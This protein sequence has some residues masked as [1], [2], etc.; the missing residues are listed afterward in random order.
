MHRLPYWRLSA[1]YFSYFAFIGVFSP[2]FGL[3]LQSLSFSAWDIGVVMSQMQ[4]MRLFAP[5]LAGGL[6]DR[7]QKRILIVRTSSAAA[8]VVFFAFLFSNTF[9]TVLTAMSV[10]SFCW[11]AALPLVETLTFD[12]LRENPARYS[13]IRVWGSIG[14]VVAVLGTG[15][16]L[17][18]VAIA[19]LVWIGLGSLLC[20]F[21]SAAVVPDAE[22]HVSG[23]ERRPVGQILR[24]PRV[25][26]LFAA[27]FAAYAAHAALNIFYSILLSDH[28]Y[29]KS[30][31]GMLWT[32]GVIVE[33]GVFFFMPR[34]MRRFN[35]RVILLASL[36][37]AVVRFVMIGA[38]VDLPAILVFAQLLHG[39]T[40]GSFH[41]AAIAAVNRWFP[42]STRSRGQ[43][44]YS[45]LSF[46]AGG[47]VGGLL[48]GWTWG[49][50]GGEATFALSSVYALIGFLLVARY[51]KKSDVSEQPATGVVHAT[52]NR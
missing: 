26:A 7:L 39:L 50:L 20:I 47:L 8:L 51:V 9:L 1:Y 30:A 23:T 2:Y 45:S 44:L 43:A 38:A 48:S 42:D 34:L 25:L 5:Y 35:L 10:F 46:G 3:Y 49:S 24:Q 11:A 15:A 29:S 12:H 52:P 19:N 14:F 4:L 28:G 27:C 33:I 32:I 41:A 31:V 37:A 22:G 6:S 17:D 18:R 13:R 16:L 21:A 40:F 36:G